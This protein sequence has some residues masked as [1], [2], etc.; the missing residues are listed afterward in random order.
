MFK[1][2]KN[3]PFLL[4]LLMMNAHGDDMP[5]LEIGFLKDNRT[6]QKMVK[7]LTRVYGRAEIPVTFIEVP[8]RR[9]LSSANRGTLAGDVGRVAGIDKE[10]PNLVPLPTPVFYIRGRA[11]SLRPELPEINQWAD[12]HD[13]HVGIVRGVIY[14]KKGVEN[15][16]NTIIT[17]H[18]NVHLFK[19][20][21]AGR[22]DYAITESDIAEELLKRDF[23]GSGIYA[24]GKVLFEGVLYHYLNKKY[25]K[26]FPVIDQAIKEI[27][28]EEAVLKPH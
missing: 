19:L 24:N 18:D 26:L 7:F 3:I 15:R 25:E 13:Y 1:L 27:H 4:A 10:Y 23:A 5:V 22:I 28:K 6:S 21:I 16:V 17:A 20:L 9:S 11:F 8:V 12:L 2:I 14:S